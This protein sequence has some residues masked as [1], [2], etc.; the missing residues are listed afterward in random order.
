MMMMIPNNPPT[1][2]PT[3]KGVLLFDLTAGLT[4]EQIFPD[5]WE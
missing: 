3:I 1:E 2:Q 4:G 5:I